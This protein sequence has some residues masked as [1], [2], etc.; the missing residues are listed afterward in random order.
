MTQKKIFST[1]GWAYFWLATITLGISYALAFILVMAAPRIYYLSLMNWVI[2]LAPMYLVGMPVCGKVMNRLPGMQLFRKKITPGKWC[3]LFCICI[4]V[5]YAGN[6]IG[7]VITTMLDESTSLDLDFDLQNLMMTDNLLYVFLFSVLL[8]PVLEELF[9][10]KIL[11]D[12]AIVFGDKTAIFLSGLMFGL[13]HG[14]LYQVFY[15]FGVGCVLAYVYIRTGKLRYCISLHM[16]VNFF[17]GFLSTLIQRNLD[18]S[19]LLSGSFYSEAALAGY[20]LGHLGALAAYGFYLICSFVLGIIG[21]VK[22]LTS[23]RRL[24]FN[25][26]EYTVPSRKMA[27]YLFQNVGMW[28]FFGICIFEFILSMI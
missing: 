15:A 6:I 12:R 4:C 27:E 19:A 22:L 11:I 3:S 5:M 17:G 21:L 16:A 25:P 20:M 10:R 28:M 18:L 9:F 1:I 13:F 7:N 24:R 14:N 26:G 8:A 2:S 23:I